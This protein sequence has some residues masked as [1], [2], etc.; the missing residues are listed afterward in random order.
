MKLDAI[1]E[2]LKSYKFKIIKAEKSDSF[3]DFY[4]IFSNGLVNIRFIS[5]RS[6]TTIAISN[7]IDKDNWYDL[8][9]IKALLYHEENLN[10]V[11]PIDESV[12]FLEQELL[13]IIEIFNKIN[14]SSTKS[15][16][17][18]LEDKRVKQMFPLLKKK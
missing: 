17:R 9:I 14:Y 18:E 13:V 2:F 11:F 12:S 7:I 16:L 10:N 15:K 4:D 3:G 6:Q 5:S 1:Y 8:A